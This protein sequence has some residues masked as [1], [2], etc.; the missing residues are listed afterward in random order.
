MLKPHNT[1]HSLFPEVDSHR[2]REPPVELV[3]CVPVEKGGL[4]HPRVSEGQ[5]LDQIVVVPVNHS[6]DVLNLSVN[7][8]LH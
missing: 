7:Q 6:A 8:T 5:Q 4:S 1:H 2:G 3:V